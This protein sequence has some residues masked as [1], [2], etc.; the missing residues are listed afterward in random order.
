MHHLG[1]LLWEF[2]GMENNLK[3]RECRWITLKLSVSLHNYFQHKSHQLPTQVQITHDKMNNSCFDSSNTASVNSS[4]DSQ[5]C[6]QPHCCPPCIII[7]A[8]M[9]KTVA[10]YAL[11][12]HVWLWTLIY[13]HTN[14]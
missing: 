5:Q 2:Q 12:L 9:Y 8:T 10:S 6:S 14:L 13:V 1:G 3:I 11:F 4:S 7:T